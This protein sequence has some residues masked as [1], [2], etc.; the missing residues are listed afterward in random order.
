MSWNIRSLY[1]GLVF[2]MIAA[3]TV[4]A[5]DDTE[6]R[7]KSA[8]AVLNKHTDSPEH[9]IWPEQMAS[10]DCVAV[11][12]GFK[13]GAVGIGVGFGRGFISCRSGANW[14]APGTVTLESGSLGARIGGE[15][16]D[17]VVLIAR[18]AIVPQ[19]AFRSVHDRL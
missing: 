19:A 10:A 13:K 8:A 3:L 9:G 1:L 2:A 7:L 14:S 17:I 16:V 12:P 11:I 4:A 15:N 18:K 5:S 6:G